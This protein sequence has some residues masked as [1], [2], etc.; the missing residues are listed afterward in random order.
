M[1]NAIVT[2]NNLMVDDQEY[3][4]RVVDITNFYTCPTKGFDMFQTNDLSSTINDLADKKYQWAAINIIGHCVDTP[5]VYFKA[6]E[7]CEQHNY[8]LMGHI[9]YKPNS[10]PT[11]DSQFIILNLQTWIDVGRPALVLSNQRYDFSSVAIE[12]SLENFHDDY[13]PYWIKPSTEFIQHRGHVHGFGFDLV[14]SLLEA[15]YTIGNFDHK[16]RNMKWNLYAELNYNQLKAFFKDGSVEYAPG[17]VPMII[18]RILTERA[19]LTNTVYVL[20]SEDI[21]PNASAKK[22]ID[23]YIG[24][25]SGFKGILLLNK[26]GFSENTTVTYIDISHAALDYQ[27]YLI[28]HWDGS[29]SN[30]KNIV[31]SY[32]QANPNVRIAWRSW[33]E[34]HDEINTFLMQANLTADE[35]TILWQRYRL[36]KINCVQCDL[37]DDCSKLFSQLQSQLGNTYIWVS[38]AFDMQWTRFMLGNAYTQEKFHKFLSQLRALDTTGVVENAG[39]FYR[40]G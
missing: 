23:H 32:Q 34:W 1:N 21:Y 25:A 36:L 13:T 40:L 22:P 9:I 20:N 3:H 2:W 28:E 27:Q 11:I 31:D 39:R 29:I 5:A 12:R 17:H 18:D 30:Y 33:N 4:Q 38:N 26:F 7:Q 6:I 8:P 15:G 16:L 19:S 35:F 14:R 37:L 10:Y 24:V